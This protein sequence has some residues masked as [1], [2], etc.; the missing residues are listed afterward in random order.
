MKM[1]SYEKIE[2]LATKNAKNAIISELRDEINKSVNA[3]IAECLEGL[4]SKIKKLDI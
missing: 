4:I 2:Q 3:E 1:T